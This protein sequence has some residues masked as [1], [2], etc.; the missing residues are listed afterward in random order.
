M[1]GR[2]DRSVDGQFYFSNKLFIRKNRM[3]LF[4]NGC[5]TTLL[6]L[7]FHVVVV[8]VASAAASVAVTSWST[9]EGVLHP[10]LLC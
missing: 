3:E 9:P 1:N 6:L 8:V 5:E 7:L 4:I 10:Q 2:M